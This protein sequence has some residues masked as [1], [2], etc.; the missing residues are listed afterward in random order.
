MKFN[1]NVPCSGTE[2]RICYQHPVFP[3]YGLALSV[4]EDRTALTC[5]IVFGDISDYRDLEIL[6]DLTAPIDVFVWAFTIMQKIQN[7]VNGISVD[8]EN[9]LSTS[10]YFYQEK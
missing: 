8:V 2:R 9:L 10:K 7:T 3:N 4:N 1:F 5:C 6:S